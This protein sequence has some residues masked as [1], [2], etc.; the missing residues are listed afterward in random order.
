MKKPFRFG[1]I[2]LNDAYVIATSFALVIAWTVVAFA[3]FGLEATRRGRVVA[4]GGDMSVWF[5][6]GAAIVV[7]IVGALIVRHRL[8]WWSRLEPTQG[9]VERIERADAGLRYYYS[10]EAKGTRYR[11]HQVISPK[12]E[13]ARLQPGEPIAIFMDPSAPKRVRLI[14]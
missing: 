2:F 13:H 7:T 9:V 12:S 6:V 10:Y 5:A 1:T 3:A 4:Q 14:S 11:S 8:Q